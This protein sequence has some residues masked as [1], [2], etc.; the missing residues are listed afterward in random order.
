M[1]DFNMSPFENG[2]TG[3][4]ELHGVCSARI[5]AEGSRKVQGQSYPYFYNPAWA[6]IASRRH[7]SPGT[8]H[9]SRSSH[10]EHFWH[11]FDQV[12]I[13]PSLLGAFNLDT[14]Q[15]VTSAGDVSLLDYRGR[16]DKIEAS[17]HLP[18]LFDLD[19]E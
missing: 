10:Y 2:M 17:D 16:P 3:A 13:R 8:Y 18:I 12:L 14:L 19:I 6:L 7:A 15:I 11:T 5:A 9:Y 1:G 4:R